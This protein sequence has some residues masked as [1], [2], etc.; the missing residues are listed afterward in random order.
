[1][2]RNPQL[3]SGRRPR[4]VRRLL[5]RQRLYFYPQMQKAAFREVG[6]LGARFDN[7][8]GGRKDFYTVRDTILLQGSYLLSLIT[9]CRISESRYAPCVYPLNHESQ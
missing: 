5:F 7:V 2:D 4:A 8:F 9:D 3:V 6:K 1:M